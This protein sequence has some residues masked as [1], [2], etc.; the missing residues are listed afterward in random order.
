M[1]YSSWHQWKMQQMVHAMMSML[2]QCTLTIACLSADTCSFILLWYLDHMLLNSQNHSL[3]NKWKGECNVNQG[4]K[5]LIPCIHF[6]VIKRYK[7]FLNPS[8]STFVFGTLT[9]YL[10]A[11]DEFKAA[12]WSSMDL[13]N[14]THNVTRD[15]L[16]REGDWISYSCI[17]WKAGT[18]W[19]PVPWMRWPGKFK[20]KMSKW[21][22]H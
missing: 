10:N 14:W 17:V 3:A 19:E 22:I 12:H 18:S 11:F 1:L 16:W 7:Y 5:I 6:T 2:L 20:K 15:I 4:S 8:P 13:S 21:L 9:C